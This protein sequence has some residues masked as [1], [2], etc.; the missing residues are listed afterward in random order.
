MARDPSSAGTVARG[1]LTYFPVVPGRIEFALRLR[2]YLLEHTPR[3][4]AVELP[5]SL[6]PEYSRTMQRMPRMSVIL[7]P[8]DYFPEE[9]RATYIPVEPGDPFIEALRTAGEIGAEIVFLEPATHQKP[10]LPAT[11][12][13]PYALELIGMERYVE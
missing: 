1:N 9:D 2:R 6:E 8:D 10:H 3:V 13:E 7:I 4:I 11:Y 12:P 5:S